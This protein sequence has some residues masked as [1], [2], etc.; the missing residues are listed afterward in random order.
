MES[1]AEARS[2]DLHERVEAHGIYEY[3][4]LVAGIDACANASVKDSSVGDAWLFDDLSILVS[5]DMEIPT[6]PSGAVEEEARR[7]L[8]DLY[9]PIDANTLRS[10][11]QREDAASELD[12]QNVQEHLDIMNAQ[13]G[14]G[15]W[16][17]AKRIF[18]LRKR[19][20][21]PPDRIYRHYT[22]AWI[23]RSAIFGV[24]AVLIAIVLGVA[25]VLVALA[26]S[27]QID[28]NLVM[29]GVAVERVVD[30]YLSN[31]E[32]MN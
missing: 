32:G 30:Y 26:P 24:C 10:R 28:V 14:K 4:K 5:K 13:D 15:L 2:R 23:W 19:D 7:I 21:D 12:A 6:V 22:R 1:I 29:D 25:A 3:K 20:C 31:A 9:Q 27:V 18:G 17:R 16:A 11:L 8:G